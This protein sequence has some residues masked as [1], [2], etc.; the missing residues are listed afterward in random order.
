MRIGTMV[1]YYKDVDLKKRFKAVLELGMESC[2]LACWDPEILSDLEYAKKAKEAAEE[3][4][5]VIS[6]FWCGYGGNIV[7]NF[8]EGQKTLG[9]V[10]PFTRVDRVR[11]LLNGSEFAKILGV[12]YIITHVGYIPEN[13]YDPSYRPT[14][15]AVKIIAERCKKNGQSFLFETGQETPVTLRRAIQDVGYDNLGINLDGA[16][17]VLYG[18][19]NPVDALD[20]FGEYVKGIH[21][22][23]GFYPT[24]GTELGREVK[25]GEGKVNY[26]ELIKK[27]VK[28]YGYDGDLTIERE[29]QEGSEEQHKDIVDTRDYLKNIIS[30]L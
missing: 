20:V 12:K 24:N 30:L 4:G 9:L 8:Y 28:T 1:H 6:H 2:Q 17:L 13:P 19:A 16:N 23:D 27:L 21:V 22:K 18:K 5:I 15:E 29:I 11:D 25:V 3:T 7:W 14:I 26:P 10:P